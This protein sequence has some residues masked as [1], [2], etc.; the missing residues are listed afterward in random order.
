MKANRE[1]RFDWPLCHEAE[2]FILE[3]LDSFVARNTFAKRLSDRMLTAAGT[4]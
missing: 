1:K 2:Q 3:R 4:L